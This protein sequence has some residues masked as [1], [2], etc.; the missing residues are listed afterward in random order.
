MRAYSRVADPAPQP[1]R[2]Q[3][4]RAANRNVSLAADAF[5]FYHKVPEVIPCKSSGGSAYSW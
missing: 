5:G 3:P 2:R 4:S 1:G